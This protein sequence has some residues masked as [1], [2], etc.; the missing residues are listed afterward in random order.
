MHNST[1]NWDAIAKLITAAFL[2][3]VIT[4]LARPVARSFGLGEIGSA[5]AAGAIGTAT[6]TAI[7][8]R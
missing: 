8:T 2:A 1:P 4:E 5:A 7:A 6:V 3:Y